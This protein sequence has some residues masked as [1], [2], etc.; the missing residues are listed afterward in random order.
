MNDEA[1]TVL[2]RPPGLR[3]GEAA[4]MGKY[5]LV[6]AIIPPRRVLQERNT[7]CAVKYCHFQYR[8]LSL[9]SMVLPNR[10]IV[11]SR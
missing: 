9:I 6:T 7:E 1:T 4:L 10:S 11:R 3:Q 5:C 2:L 8:V